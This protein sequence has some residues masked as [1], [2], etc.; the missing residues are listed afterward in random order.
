MIE[1]GLYVYALDANSAIN[2]E[3]LSAADYKLR[4]YAISLTL[5]VNKEYEESSLQKTFKKEFNV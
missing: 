5:M 4:L 3:M 1:S 2:N